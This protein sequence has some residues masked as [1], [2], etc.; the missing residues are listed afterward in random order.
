MRTRF[1]VYPSWPQYITD[2]N[3]RFGD[4]Y[5]DPLSTLIQVRH[6]GKIQEYVDKFEL[7]LTH[8]SLPPEH[9]L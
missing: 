9:T 3:L 4:P 5:D 1:D 6:S 7:A 2:V 8:I